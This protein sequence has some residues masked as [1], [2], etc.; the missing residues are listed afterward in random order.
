MRKLAAALIALLLCVEIVRITA[1]RALARGR[2]ADAAKVWAGHPQVQLVTGLTAIATATREGRPVTRAMLSSIYAAAAKAPLLPDP[3]LVRG[4]EAQ[5]AGN[6]RLAEQA[7]I[8][9]SRR[10]ARSLPARFFLADTYFRRGDARRG[11]PEIGVLARL[12][13]DGANK[14]AP[15]VASYAKNRANWPL[16]RS[17]LTY[18]HNLEQAALATLAADAANADAV[19]ALTSPESRRPGT[20]WLQPLL[21]NLVAAGDYAKAKEIWARWS[22]AVVPAGA[23]YDPDFR[24]AAAPAPFNWTLTSSTVGFAE[25]QKGGGLHVT[26]YGHEDGALAS[27]LLLLPPGRYAL[28]A[29]GSA[30]GGNVDPLR[31]ALICAKGNKSI[32]TSPL[33][34]ALAGGWAFDV[35]ADCPA[36]RLEL[37]GSASDMP[38][39]A[40]VTLRSVRLSRRGGNA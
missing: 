14:L 36:Q 31:W 33:A 23:L 16:V 9:A 30:N 3:F 22:R 7:F 2:P 12:V 6:P 15:Y 21:A 1:V 20:P 38:Q 11:L 35:P 13:P 10:D 25:R 17:L 24:D 39:Q 29:S 28:S 34:A 27:Q 8:E 37:Q 4:V 32:A 40:E 18:D 26:Y 5:F 19:V